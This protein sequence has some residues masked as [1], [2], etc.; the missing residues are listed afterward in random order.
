MIAYVFTGANVNTYIYL[1]GVCYA[2]IYICVCA[3]TGTDS[4]RLLQASGYGTDMYI[5]YIPHACTDN[6]TRSPRFT[7]FGR[8][9]FIV[10]KGSRQVWLVPMVEGLAAYNSLVSGVHVW[11]E[12]I[13]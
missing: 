13:V 11:Y 2:Q 6:R 10:S 3:L 4:V 12:R 8:I 7:P 1:R 5:R 9:E